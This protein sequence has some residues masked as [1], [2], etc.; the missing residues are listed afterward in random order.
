MGKKKI[1]VLASTFPRWA[2]DTTPPFVEE[3]S[4]RL[5]GQFEV[6][7][8]APHYPGALR[9]EIREGLT[10]YRFRY[11]LSRFE[12]LA[13]E[14]AILPALRANR[15]NYLLLPLFVLSECVSAFRLVRHLRFDC[16]HA[17]WLLPQGVIAAFIKIAVGTPFLVTAHGADVY[18]LR[19]W[20]PSLL[21]RFTLKKADRVTA[22]SRDLAARIDELVPA[23]KLSV[24]PMGVDA[25]VFR[26]E[27]F[28]PAI[29]QRYN[30]VGEFLLFV[31]RLSEKKGVRYLLESLPKVVKRFPDVKLMVIGK[32]ELE[33]ELHRTS[34]R[35]DLTDRVIFTGA[36]PNRELPAY[37][38]TA[39][40][41][42][43]PSITSTGGDTEGF[44]LTFV[45]AGLSGCQV[46]GTRTGGIGDIIEEGKT[47]VLV[48]EKD[49]EALS[50][51]IISALN[52]RAQRGDLRGLVRQQL[53]D[54]FDW[55]IIARKYRKIL[56]EI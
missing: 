45:E 9:K 10:I 20:L 21:K 23:L 44:G 29:R 49:P 41:F 54:Q 50:L 28:D 1:L 32:G 17:H 42:V 37:Y 35:L 25:T 26:P 3:L 53:S 13:G 48:D 4:K 47:G 2:N 11:C 31:G 39:D 6:T 36:I 22:V 40:L 5:A 56:A 52:H 43:G 46:I 55:E 12:V 30:I 14:K 24:I 18:G 15:L 51:A 34:R 7:V 16:I 38:A 8:L 27:L 33:E 19:G